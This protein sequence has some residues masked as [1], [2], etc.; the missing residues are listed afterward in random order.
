MEF[1][2]HA[3]CTTCGA[4]HGNAF[5]PPI[6]D[7]DQYGHA[8]AEPFGSTLFQFVRCTKCATVYLQDPVM[9]SEIHR[10]YEGE[11][12]CY[13]SYAERGVVF[14]LLSRLLLRSKLNFIRRHMPS[15]SKRILDYGCGSGTWLEMIKNAQTGYE[16]VGTDIVPEQIARVRELG[17]EAHVTREDGLAAAV[18]AGSVGLVH[19]FHVI[20]HIPDPIE[21]LRKIAQILPPGGVIF[22]Q[23]PNFASWDRALFGRY[24]SQW[25]APRHLTIYT[26][27]SLRQ[28]AIKAGLEV[29]EI[30]NS[31]VSATNWANSLLKAWTISRKRPYQP[32]TGMAYPALTLA[33][34]PLT[35]LQSLVSR[36]SSIDFIFRKAV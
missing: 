13:K 18:P 35:L 23:T 7:L 25:H 15:S 22:G 33:F 19:M 9:Q 16:L 5:M 20:E 27:D 36:T 10:Y 30:R 34:L 12:H 28:Q 17:I 4:D 31:A 32:G 24:W 8:L 3:R 1:Q 11:Y 2:E 14:R 21:A 26:P 29:L 6:G